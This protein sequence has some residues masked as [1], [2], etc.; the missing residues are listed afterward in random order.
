MSKN[1]LQ[2]VLLRGNAT[3]N[4]L[5]ALLQTDYIQMLSSESIEKD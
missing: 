1:V 5:G 3:T 4:W 2:H